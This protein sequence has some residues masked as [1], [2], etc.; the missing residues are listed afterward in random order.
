[1]KNRMC[2]N[3]KISSND[4]V[5]I[6]LFH[7][8]GYGNVGDS[9]QMYAAMERLE[10]LIPQCKVTVAKMYSCDDGSLLGSRDTIPSFHLYVCRNN[11]WL[12]NLMINSLRK[13]Q[14]KRLGSIIQ[15]VVLFRRIFW[16]LFASYCYKFFG[17]LP[18]LNGNAKQ[19]LK[20]IAKCDV[21]YCSGGGNL[22]DI[23]LTSE[24]IPRAVTYRV[25]SVFNK[26]LIV[27][28]QG[29]GPLERKIGK[30][31][32][33]WGLKNAK[34]IGCRDKSE[35]QLILKELGLV[36]NVKS[37][38][39]DATDLKPCSKAR[40][41]EIFANEGL[42]D[43]DKPL[44]AVHVRL[45]NFSK[46]FRGP[47]IPILAELYDQ[48]IQR[49]NC[50]ILFIPV[51]YCKTKAYEGD[52]GDAFEVYARMKC[53]SGVSFICKEKYSPPEMKGIIAEC[54]CL[55]AFSYHAWVFG[56]S[57]GLPTF[58]FY[59]GDYFRMKSSGLFGLYGRTE[60]VWEIQM[61]DVPS[62]INQIQE[63]FND[64]SFHKE[65]LLTITQQ[66]ITQVE[67]PAMQVDMRPST[68]KA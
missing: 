44:I 33:R 15:W 46:D 9:A 28:G 48:I 67:L 39:D 14:M 36:D 5:K 3:K 26:V 20:C 23:W 34:I 51:T 13:L 65:H 63:V 17:F 47:A 18:I 50:R 8:S 49:L 57:C 59:Y 56:L 21:V 19:T 7:G 6:V 37:L 22:N 32:L 27:S 4:A 2:C 29:I 11:N 40:V 58:G 12:V 42:P 53:R 38:G 35:S 30:M 52:I 64:C 10:S 16:L 66:I 41:D 54:K 45:H 61:L 68:R 43:S 60:W 25:A 62:T 31:F 24:L 55:I 1:M